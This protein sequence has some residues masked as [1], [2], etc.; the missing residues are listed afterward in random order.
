MGYSKNVTNV[1]ASIARPN[2]EEI[3]KKTK[4]EDQRNEQKR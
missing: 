1:G 4:E 3:T 2:I